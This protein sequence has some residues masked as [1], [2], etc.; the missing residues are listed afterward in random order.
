M[1]AHNV[2]AVVAYEP[3]SYFIFP[4]GEVPP[5]MPS[6]AGPLEAVGVPLAEFML[7]TKL[8]IIIFYGDNIPKEPSANPGQDGWRVRLAMARRWAEAVNRRGGDVTVVHLPELGVRGN[9]H[10]PFSDLNNLEIAELLS[11]FLKKKGLD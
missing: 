6:A 8:P 5:A 1:K 10:F 4:D 7:L 11:A 9:T 3:S 2:R